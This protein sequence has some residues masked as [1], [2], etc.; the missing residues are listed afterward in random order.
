MTP[1]IKLYG[2]SCLR[3]VSLAVTVFD[4]QK[5]RILQ[6]NMAAALKRYSGIGLAAPQIGQNIRCILIDLGD[7][8]DRL[9]SKLI[10]DGETLAD[11]GGIVGWMAAASLQNGPMENTS[12]RQKNSPFRFP[13]FMINPEIVAQ[14]EETEADSEGCLSLPACSA[15]V[16][17]PREVRVQYYDLQKNHHWIETDGYFAR[18]IQHEIDH[19]DGILYVDRLAEDERRRVLKDFADRTRPVK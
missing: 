10:V 19:L 2:E 6:N 1:E 3:E 14:S 12:G 5:L 17:R 4:H 8:S 13:L 11:P 16:V 18:C 7:N 9:Y 15:K